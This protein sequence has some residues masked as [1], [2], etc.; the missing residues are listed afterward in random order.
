[1]DFN[2]DVSIMSAVGI[3]DLG[4][5][6]FADSTSIEIAR[7]SSSISVLFA[8]MILKIFPMVS[9]SGILLTLALLPL[10]T[11]YSSEE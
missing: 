7:D 4:I 11:K 1:M 10:Q 8:L 9:L 2:I 3:N 5:P 6:D